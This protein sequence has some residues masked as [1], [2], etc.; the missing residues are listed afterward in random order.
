MNIFVLETF[1]WMSDEV[2]VQDQPFRIDI[3]KVIGSKNPRLL[4]M[5]PGFVLRWIERTLHQEELNKFVAD[6][7]HHKGVAFAQAIVDGFEINCIS[8]GLEDVP[9]DNSYIFVANHPQGALESMC[10]ITR[11]NARFGDLRFLVN[12]VLLNVKNLSTLFVP[13]NLF[14]GQS[15]QA[16]QILDDTFNGK[17]QLL[18]YPAGL[19]SRKGKNGIADTEWKKTFISRSV[20]HQKDVVPVY[21]DARNSNR[22]YRIARWRKFLGIKANIE[23]FYLPDEMYRNKGN[24]ITLVFGKPIP[25]TTFDK[26]KTHQEWAKHV[27]EIVYS[28]KSILSQTPDR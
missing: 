28:Q 5:L 23:M 27:R 24:T 6:N 26:S 17:Y 22:F 1:L 15:R 3:R 10:L 7:N 8:H 16:A 13:I 25:W 14:G 18:Y 21:I 19:V 2:K 9:T 12:D 20:R 4:K 11:V